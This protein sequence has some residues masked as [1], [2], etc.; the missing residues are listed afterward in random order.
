MI[1]QKE[2]KSKNNKEVKISNA[3]VGLGG[4][5]AFTLIA[6]ARPRSGQCGRAK[7]KGV[8]GEGNFCPPAGIFGEIPA[9]RLRR[10]AKSRRRGFLGRKF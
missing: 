4:T 8:L 6:A 9:R 5:R 2:N 7:R 3:R 10:R 1:N